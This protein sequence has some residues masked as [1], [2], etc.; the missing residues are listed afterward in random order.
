MSAYRAKVDPTDRNYLNL[1]V[2]L[3]LIEHRLPARGRGFKNAAEAYEWTFNQK[4]VGDIGS[5]SLFLF[6][7]VSARIDVRQELGL[8]REALR[9]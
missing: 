2:A 8:M 9:P 4:Y 6:Q 3:D 5:V 7:H 1:R